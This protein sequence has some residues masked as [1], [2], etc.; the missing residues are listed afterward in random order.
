MAIRVFIVDDSAVV[1]KVLTEM[2]DGITGIEVIGSAQD[3][4]FAQARMEKDWPDVITLDV[5]M[6]RMDG[7]S[8]LRKIMNERPTPVVMCSTLTEEGSQG[9]PESI[10]A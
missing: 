10:P 6:P 3:P 2:L 9:K 5:E 1:R 7:I 8:F 4:I